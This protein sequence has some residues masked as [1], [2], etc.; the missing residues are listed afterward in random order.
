MNATMNAS[1]L[2]LSTLDYVFAALSSANLSLDFALVFH[3]T[4]APSFESLNAG[5]QSARNKFPTTSSSIYRGRWEYVASPDHGIEYASIRDSKRVPELIEK[6]LNVPFDLRVEL[7]YRQLFITSGSGNSVLVTRF[8]HAVADGLS[9]AMWLSH[10]LRVAYLLEKPIIAPAPHCE[11]LLRENS[12]STRRSRFA[13]ATPSDK[14]WTSNNKR[15][16][17]RQW[18]SFAFASNE[19]RKGC[20]RA[21]GFTFSDLLAVC[22]LETLATWN[23]A[24]NHSDSTQIGLWFPMNIRNKSACGFG[25]G[26]SR[27]RLYPRYDRT[28]SLVD[29]AREVRRQ[30]SWC[31][32]NGEWVVPRIPLLLKLPKRTLGRALSFYLNRS[33][34]D[35]ATGVFSHAD[36]W[37]NGAGEVF[38]TIDRIEAI[39]LLHPRQAVAINGTTLHGQTSLTLTYD[40]GVLTRNEAAQLTDLYQQQIAKAREELICEG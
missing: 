15:S 4:K 13:Y 19:L 34:V 36:S 12:I 11:P 6:F 33:S 2:K 26:T 20:R 27:I 23:Q 8:H 9:A 17:K 3:F 30:V 22:T 18:T 29:K 38:Q 40:S 21:G 39:G 25:N 10:Q 1:E 24:K 32:K 16:T 31:T 14:L 7:P 37:A 35:M 28:A 5:A